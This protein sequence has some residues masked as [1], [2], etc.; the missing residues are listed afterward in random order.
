M[1]TLKRL[2]LFHQIGASL[3]P[4][5]QHSDDFPTGCRDRLHHV[6]LNWDLAAVGVTR[7]AVVR[8]RS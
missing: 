2:E 7:D 6:Y 3:K 5:G 4:P 1:P 8:F